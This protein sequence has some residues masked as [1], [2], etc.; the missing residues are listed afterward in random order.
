[1]AQKHHDNIAARVVAVLFAGFFLYTGLFG[2]F[3]PSIQRTVHTGAAVALGLLFYAP[4]RNAPKAVFLAVDAFLAVVA[5]AVF[6]YFVWNNELL[7]NWIVFVSEYTATHYA[8]SIAATLLILEVGRRATGY[9]LP[10][11]GIIFLV[12]GRFGFLLP[13]PLFHAGLSWKKIMEVMYFGFDGVF[14]IP[15]AVSATFIVI[16]IIFGSFFEKAGGGQALMIIGKY[17]A[18]RA[19]GGPAKIAVIGSSLFGTISGSAVANVYTTGTFSIPLMKK[20]GY[21]PSFAGAVEACAST[22]GQLAPPIMGAAAFVMAELTGFPYVR[23]IAAALIPA[24]LYYLSIFLRVD[25]EAASQGIKGLPKEDLPEGKEVLLQAPLL[26]PLAV[27]IILLVRGHSAMLAGVYAIFTTVAVSWLRKET[28]ITPLRFLEALEVAGK[29]TVTIAVSTAIAGMIIG[30]VSYTGLGLN[31]VGIVT[32]LTEGIVWIGPIMVAV[33]SIILGMSVPTTVAYIIV[34]AVAVP[35]LRELGFDLLPAH[36]F[37]FYFAVISMIS[38]PVAPASLAASEI[39]GT[40]FFRTGFAACQIGLVTFVIPFMFLYSPQLLMF[41]TAGRVILAT[42]TAAI[43]VTGFTAGLK[44]WLI[45]KLSYLERALFLI[46]G[47][48]MIKPGI[49]TDALGLGALGVGVV[50]MIYRKLRLQRKQ[51]RKV[52]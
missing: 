11:V 36:M 50:S 28:R 16:F 26:L 14:G 24:V 21:K 8:L 30:I 4:W 10:I 47:M 48:A 18:G 1:M 49:T 6:G 20:L 25:F 29:R 33:A 38:P 31:F 9:T 3:P 19:R 37:A 42:A 40:S 27:L 51:D 45:S 44:G 32:G 35:A 52:T 43:G 13:G 22:G 39:A 34:A 15:V 17:L 12:Y 2:V 23:I 41:G 5:I 46:G 7:S